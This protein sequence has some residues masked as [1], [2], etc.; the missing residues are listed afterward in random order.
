MCQVE[1]AFLVDHPEKINASEKIDEYLDLIRELKKLRNITVTVTVI[2]IVDGV[3]GT[4]PN[5]EKR[6]LKLKIRE[7]IK[8]IRTT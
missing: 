4:V 5:S 2:P 7:R 3:P 1:F 6:L 8:T